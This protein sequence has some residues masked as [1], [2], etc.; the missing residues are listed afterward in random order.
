MSIRDRN[1]TP[2]NAMNTGMTIPEIG[3]FLVV[4]YA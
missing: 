1:E 2:E 4:P 3:K